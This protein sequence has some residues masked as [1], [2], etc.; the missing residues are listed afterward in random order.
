MSADTDAAIRAIC[1]AVVA[2]DWPR[3][4]DWIADDGV[5]Y[6]T[7]GGIDEGLV[8]HGPQAVVDYFTEAAAMWES[9]RFEV[10][11]VRRGG[12]GLVV[13]F[14]RETTRTRHSDVELV[15]QTAITF[16]LRDGQVVEGRGYMSRADALAAAGLA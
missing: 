3:L 5:F 10:D 11:E 14:W 8:A 2:G 16:R 15:N 7:L 1:D 13:V 6:G 4:R 9:W 12:D